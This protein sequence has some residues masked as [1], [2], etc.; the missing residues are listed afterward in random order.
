MRV[1]V[2]DSGL[3]CTCVTYFE[4]WLTPLNNNETMKNE[5][6]ICFLLSYVVSL[7][8]AWKIVGIVMALSW[9]CHGTV[10]ALSGHCQGIVRAL[11]WH[12]H[13]NILGST[14]QENNIALSNTDKW[15]IFHPF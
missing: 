6:L 10:M 4:C 13:A 7:F 8:S 1:T 2:S 9:H 12:I 14:G 5:P 11:S 15:F 3:C